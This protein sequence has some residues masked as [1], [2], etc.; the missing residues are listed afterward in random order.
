MARGKYLSF[1]EVRVTVTVVTVTVTEIKGTIFFIGDRGPSDQ[2][3]HP[4]P[5]RHTALSIR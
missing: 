4:V 2:I 5:A 1:E 3:H